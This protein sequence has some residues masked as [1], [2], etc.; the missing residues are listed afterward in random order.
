MIGQLDGLWRLLLLLG[1]LLLLQRALQREIQTILL[2]LTRRPEISLAIFSILFFP[3]VFLHEASHWLMARLLGV[4]T[5]RFSLIPQPL[6]N[7]RVRLGFVETASPDIVRDAL[8]GVAPLISGG[9]FV[10]Y[11]GLERLNL[12]DFWQLWLNNAGTL[13]IVP[14]LFAQPDFWLWFYLV[15]TVSG[16]MMPSHSDRRAWLPVVLAV[17][18][19]VAI[20]L[21]AGA[22]P[23]MVE[24]FAPSI[25]RAFAAVSLV[26]GISVLVHALL[27]LPS[28]LAHRL[29]SA[30]MK[31]DV[32]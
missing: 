17:F 11:A 18:L 23:W 15:V 13:D 9:V 32:A 30:I 3:G 21:V 6:G 8:I 16:T 1:P 2:L 20:S 4:R 25:N 5:G 22:G 19:A 26:F 31:V 28:W 14:A 24:H 27:L 7:G 12:V 29:L 10:S